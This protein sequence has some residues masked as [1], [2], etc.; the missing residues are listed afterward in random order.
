VP[1]AAVQAELA[2]FQAVASRHNIALKRG[3]LSTMGTIRGLK[4][5]EAKSIPLVIPI[6][7][8]LKIDR[9]DLTNRVCI[10]PVR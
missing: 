2:Q 1:H 9:R 6:P 8:A 10:G 5:R 7:M 3:V 4:A